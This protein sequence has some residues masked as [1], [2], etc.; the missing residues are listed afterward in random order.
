MPQ[1]TVGVSLKTY[2][3]HEHARAWF[4][5]VAQ[6]AAAHPAVAAGDVR[7]F[8][9][10]TYLQVPAALAAF[11]GT[12]VLVGAQ[13]VSEFP[14]G[15]YTGEVTAQEL[16]E[17]GVQVAEIGH[18]ER[19]RLFDETD[20]VTAAKAAAALTHGITPVLCIGEAEQLGAPAAALA[21]VEQLATNLHGVPA[22][23]VIVAYE[24]VWAIGAAE[25]APDDHITTVTRALRAA[26]DVDPDRAGSIVIYGGSAG[27]G[28]LTRL[29]DSVDGLFLGRFAHEPSALVAVLDEATALTASV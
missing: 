23:A 25:P 19:R 4:T 27:P 24:P 3:R 29:A 11:A 16:A 13:D 18:A 15:P 1:V 9:I 5:D 22:G 20:T 6:R 10:P 7:L 21:N 14:P 17:I 26:I 2:F 28:L 12:P 8:V